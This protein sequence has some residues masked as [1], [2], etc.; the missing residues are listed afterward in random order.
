VAEHDLDVTG[1]VIAE[2]HAVGMGERQRE[3]AVVEPLTP[4][5]GRQSAAVERPRL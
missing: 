3:L 2:Q 4:K 5:V 1:V